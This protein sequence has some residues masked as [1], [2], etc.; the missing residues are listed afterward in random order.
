MNIKENIT[1]LNELESQKEIILSI[2]DT[3]SD[4]GGGGFID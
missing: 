3:W 2:K 4:I 1:C